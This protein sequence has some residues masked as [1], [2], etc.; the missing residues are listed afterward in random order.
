[1]DNC[2]FILRTAA[3]AA[4]LFFSATS[5]AA[6]PP[7]IKGLTTGTPNEQEKQTISEYGAYWCDKLGNSAA[8]PEDIREAKRGLLDPLKQ[9]SVSA[10]FLNEYDQA[11]LES[12]VTIIDGEEPQPAVVSLIVLSQLGTDKALEA[13]L[14]RSR[15]SDEPRM[16]VRLAACRGCKLLLAGNRINARRVPAATRRL[17]EAAK[18]E[19]DQNIL[20][21]QLGAILV[22]D[23]PM[24]TDTQRA[25][26]RGYLVQALDGYSKLASDSDERKVPELFDAVYPVLVE[27]RNSALKLE[28]QAQREFGK[29]LGPCLAKLLAVPSVHWEKAQGSP[30]TKDRYGK[31]I[32]FCEGF[33]QRIDLILGG[34][35]GVQQAN[36][37]EAWD[38]GSREQYLEGLAT[39]ET[40]LSRPTYE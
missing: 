3:A 9:M 40:V 33:L 13:M 31:A 30:E 12:L 34:G 38:A 1:M 14:D 21:H 24:L 35:G 2:R 37:K 29:V 11:I 26:I 20:R 16:H 17:R 10:A 15:G 4:V 28:P 39:L 8:D 6:A 36:L 25:Q 7:S 32:Q 18:E 22:A 19:S 27:V 23:Q 5:L